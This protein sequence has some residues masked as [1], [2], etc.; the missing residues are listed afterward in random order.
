MWVIPVASAEFV[1]AMELVLEVYMRAY[2]A[3]RPVI[4]LDESPKQLIS[5]SRVPIKK[6]DGST[7]YDSEYIR[8]GVAQVYML[9]E[10]L[11]GKRIVEVRDSNNRLEW[12]KI[13]AD[14][15]EKHYAHA[16]KITIVQ[17]NL[18]AHKP[19][20]L[21]E[22]FPAE[23][24]KAILDKVEFVFT[25]KHG[26]WLNMAE[27]ELSVLKRQSIK[28]RVADKQ[29]LIDNIKAW[30]QKRNEKQVGANWQFKTKD[31]RIKLAKL[32]PTI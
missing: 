22:V 12:A 15:V 6:A 14:L 25:P 4:C 19:A 29:T 18:K 10:P 26:S 11:A 9:F 8:H 32:Y 24:A 31:A 17:D 21:Y 23:R 7:F 28:G 30:Q 13:V 2:D 1:W 27:I 5:H 3:M 16:T 20:A